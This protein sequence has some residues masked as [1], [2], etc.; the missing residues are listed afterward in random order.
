M[1]RKQY[2]KGRSVGVFLHFKRLAVLVVLVLAT[3]HDAVYALEP[4]PEPEEDSNTQV[5]YLLQLTAAGAMYEAGVGDHDGVLSLIDTANSTLVFSDRP[6]RIAGTVST[7]ALLAEVFAPVDGPN[8]NSFYVD[9]PNAA[10]S[11]MV[12][13]GSVTRAVYVLRAPSLDTM[14]DT[15]LL[16]FEVDVL[17][18]DVAD[19]VSCDG[20]ASLVIDCG[21]DIGDI[22]ILEVGPVP[23]A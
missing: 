20:L 13:G 1:S 7:D 17:Y 16:T 22:L 15:S 5:K 12:M 9:P 2:A 4:A 21:D 11:C 23:S 18:T 8:D 10:F 6:E 3:I 14:T 19:D